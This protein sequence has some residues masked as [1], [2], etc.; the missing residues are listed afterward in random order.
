MRG[1]ADR[2]KTFTRRALVLVGGKLALLTVVL[3]RMYHLQVLESDRYMTLAEDNRINLRLLPPPRGRIVDRFGEPLAFNRQNF[4]ATLVAEKAKNARGVLESVSMLVPLTDHER[5][6]I[7]R[8]VERSRRYMPV[9]LRENLTWEEVSALEVNAPDLPGVV[10][11]VG[12]SRFYPL[13]PAVA[14]LV[15][16]VG[17]ASE[18]DQSHDEDPLLEL[19]GF[20][21]GKDGVEKQHDRA[22]RG[23]AGAS[24]VEVN[25]VGRIIRE[26]SREEGEPGR[27]VSLTI[28]LAVQKFAYDR[29][30]E[31]SG[32]VV[33][34]DI[35]TGELVALASV[36]GYDPNVFAEG[37]SGAK[38]RELLNNDH[39]PLVNKALAGQYAPGSTFKMIVALAAQESGLVTPETRVSCPGHY[40][41]GDSLFHCWKKEGHGSM[42]MENAIRL[43]CDVYFYEIARR[44]GIDRIAAMAKRFGLGRPLGLDLAGERPGLIPSRE[45][46][47]TALNQPWHNG[48]TLVA[49]IGQGFV[50][51]TPLQLAVMTARLANGGRA[52]TPRLTRDIKGAPTGPL[53]QP[54]ELPEIGVAAPALSVVVRGMD[55]VVNGGGTA[56]GSRI[57]DPAFAFAGKT[58]TSQ[59][60]RITQAERDRG[61]KKN[62]DLPWRQRD[63]ALFVGFGP[64]GNP[65]YAVAVLVEHGGGGSKVAAPIARDVLKL[66][67]ERDPTRPRAM[68]RNET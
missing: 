67:M 26:L 65:R 56:A 8:E 52:V 54:G 12:R 51:T 3:G 43:S 45:W 57:A 25:A 35:H 14:H 4:R 66:T 62:E 7:L 55:A 37:I 59:V 50:L 39:A 46:K 16:Y 2:Y 30:G 32:A 41:F 64:V 17:A 19:P 42:D 68:A 23:A 15:G 61:V 63:H 24:E 21:V 53:P 10:T 49:G 38:W 28:D 6:R 60:R 5:G 20:A 47:R 33:V 11:D 58:G 1:E 13:G 34:M 36:P 29:M 22:L 44:T 48:E 40:Q 27:E 31:E 9:T 18:S